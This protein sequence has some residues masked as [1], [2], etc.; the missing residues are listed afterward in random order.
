MSWLRGLGSLGLLGALG[1]QAACGEAAP[2]PEPTA[3]FIALTR[4][5]EGYRGWQRFEVGVEDLGASH[6]A[7]ARAVFAN[8]L[9]AADA[10]LTEFP[11]GTII[12]KE[13]PFNIFAMAKRG[14]G[15]NAADGGARG[16]E[17]FELFRDDQDRVSIIWRGRGPPVGE[18]YGATGETCNGCHGAHSGNDSVRSPAL[19]LR[20]PP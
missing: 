13:Q 12:V 17:W 14:D 4:D 3:G 20:S 6:P 10:G 18:Q 5:L 16:W 11:V 9:P 1:L 7:G 15:Y 2:A 8:R 19:Q